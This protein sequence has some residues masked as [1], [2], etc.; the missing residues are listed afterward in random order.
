MKA[1]GRHTSVVR[2][3]CRR[4]SVSSRCST[5]R[6]FDYEAPSPAEAAKRPKQCIVVRRLDRNGLA[7]ML[8]QRLADVVC[9]FPLLDGTFGVSEG[10][11]KRA[12][13]RQCIGRGDALPIVRVVLT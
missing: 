3:S 13:Q 10:P 5:A 8:G 1:R 9:Q 12:P 6:S 4:L 2:A 7:E 11:I